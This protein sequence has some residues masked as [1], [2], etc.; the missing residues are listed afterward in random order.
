MKEIIPF[1]FEGKQIRVVRDEN[2]EAMFVGKDI[3]EALGYADPTS[4]MKQHCR[5]VA[6]H[7]PIVDSLGRTQKVRVLTEGDMYR[8]MTHSKLEGAERFES[9]VFD[10]ILPTIRKTGKYEAPKAKEQTGLDKLRIA[11]ALEKA[12][13]VA[14]RI[15]ARFNRLGENGQ[16]VIFAKIINPLMGD[17]VI[18]LPTVQ[19]RLLTA[20]KV[21][22]VLGVSANMVGRLANKHGMKTEEFG[23][24][25][26][27]KSPHSD[28]QVETFHYNAKAVSKLREL[29]G[30]EVVA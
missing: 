7:H 12:E 1:A 13:G 23:E 8:L 20:S 24:F 17:E 10:D 2:G 18:A 21:G 9:L 5:G 11:S 28:K 3:A 19:E 15:C 30:S 4:A 22:E 27:D 29:C 26:L 6:K 14:A 25:R 16:Q